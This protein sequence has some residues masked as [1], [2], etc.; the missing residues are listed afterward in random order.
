VLLAVPMIKAVESVEADSLTADD[1]IE[2]FEPRTATTTPSPRGRCRGPTQSS[3]W[4]HAETPRAVARYCNL[5][6]FRRGTT[7]SRA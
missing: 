3:A 1:T 2:A 7:E 4:P 6:G 5:A